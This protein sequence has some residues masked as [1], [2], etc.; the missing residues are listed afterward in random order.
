VAVVRKRKGVWS[1]LSRGGER[2]WGREGEEGGR[3]CVA[4]VAFERGLFEDGWW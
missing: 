1:R 4:I 3:V 2:R